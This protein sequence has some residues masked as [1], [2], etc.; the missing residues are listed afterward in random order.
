MAMRRF[1]SSCG[2]KLIT[3]RHVTTP[4]TALPRVPD[5]YGESEYRRRPLE[6][7]SCRWVELMRPVGRNGYAVV[8]A[9]SVARPEFPRDVAGHQADG[10]QVRDGAQP[11]VAIEGAQVREGHAEAQLTHP[12][13]GH[14]AVPD[15]LGVTLED[16]LGEQL[17][18]RDLDGKLALQAEDDVQHVNR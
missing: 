14:L 6:F 12:F 10:E 16:G 5:Q 15:E 2:G 7:P 13:V 11:P 9:G 4:G 1:L 3:G 18:P 8:R 17:A